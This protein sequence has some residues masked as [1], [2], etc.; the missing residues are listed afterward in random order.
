MSKYI[1]CDCSSLL[2]LGCGEM[3]IR[4]YIRPNVKYFGCD[5]KK[6]DNDTIICDLA[7]GEFP[8]ITVDTIF[9]AGVLEY[10]ANW[11]DVLRNCRE[12]CIQLI[13]SYS[14]VD[15]APV[16]S[17]V[18]VNII[19]DSEIKEYVAS[20]GFRLINA[21]MPNENSMAYNFIKE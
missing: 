15:L 11:K 4:K 1:L 17:P 21:E 13:M 6:R 10:L 16:R 3:H 14:T 12:H 7:R 8:D 19:S 5:Y 9:I 20:L 18:W 2:D